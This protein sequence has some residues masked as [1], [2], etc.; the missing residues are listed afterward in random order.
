MPTPKKRINVE[1][2]LS[3][4]A[5]FLSLAALIVS[6]VQTKIARDQQHA[7]VW[8]RLMTS[9]S[10]LEL[11]FYFIIG[12]QGVGLAIIKSVDTFYKGHKY[13]TLSELLFQQTGHLTGGYLYG[14]LESETVLKAGDEN[15]L[16]KLT[17]NDEPL[18]FKLAEVVRDSSFH[19]RV[20]YADV[21][22]NCWLLD[23]NKVTEL[24]H[25]PD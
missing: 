5:I 22:G 8:P 2:H 14:D 10:V 11:N 3:L 15:E 23:R 18:A 24:G 25:C 4:S 7:S 13:V 17:R 16:F 12:N 21:Y 20:R 1:L 19:F 9:S 6:V